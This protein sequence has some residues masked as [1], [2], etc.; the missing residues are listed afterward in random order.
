VA[1]E[2]GDAIEETATVGNGDVGTENGRSFEVEDA[3]G[4]EIILNQ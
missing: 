2:F 1:I 3:K 4:G